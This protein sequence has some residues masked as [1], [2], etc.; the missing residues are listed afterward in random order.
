MSTLGLFCSLA[1][2]RAPFAALRLVQPSTKR[3][4]VLFHARNFARHEAIQQDGGLATR[5]MSR[6]VPTHGLE[7]TLLPVD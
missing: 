7:A 6:S 5:S 2:I 3:I 1:N 4:I